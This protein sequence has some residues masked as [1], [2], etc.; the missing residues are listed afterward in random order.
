M[1]FS[2]LEP[3]PRVEEYV[4]NGTTPGRPQKHMRLVHEAQRGM[5]KT[6]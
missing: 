3:T 5:R 6:L 1:V 2:E 4:K